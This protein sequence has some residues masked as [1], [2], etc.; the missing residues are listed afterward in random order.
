MVAEIDKELLAIMVC[1]LSRAPLVQ[2]GDWL[3]STDRETRRRYPIRD[4]IPIMLVD[5]AEE[6]EKEEFERVMADA[7]GQQAS[8]STAHEADS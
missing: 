6:V 8:E 2:V 5:E 3:Y 4:G 7:G 1:P